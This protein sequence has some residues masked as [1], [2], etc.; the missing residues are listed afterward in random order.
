MINKVHLK[1][2]CVVGSV[3][4]GVRQPVLYSFVLDKLPGYKVFCETETNR[5]KKLKKFVL[6]T[7]TFYLEDNNH[8]EV[9]FNGETL[10]FALQMIKV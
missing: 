7:I 2:D 6:K 4:R 10:N 9:V 5:Y 8:K 3:L 1:C